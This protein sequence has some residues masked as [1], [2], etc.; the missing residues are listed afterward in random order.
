MIGSLNSLGQN[1]GLA[2]PSNDSHRSNPN[3]SKIEPKALPIAVRVYPVGGKEKSEKP[4]QCPDGMLVFD[5]ETRIDQTQRL[6]F[7]SY[8]FL[9]A[10]HCLEEGIFHADDLPEPDYRILER[11]VATHS[12]DTVD[13][14]RKL[15]LL[16]RRE[17]LRKI[18][19]DAYKV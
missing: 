5:T 7:G 15:E 13:E 10:R 11:Y 14:G 1:G 3:E 17:F 9:V 8:R 19:R 16:T 2:H 12:A 6:T 4:W 18:Y